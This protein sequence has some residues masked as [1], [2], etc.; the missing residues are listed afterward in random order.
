MTYCMSENR[1]LLCWY[2]SSR[3]TQLTTR[4]GWPPINLSTK[5]TFNQQSGKR[6]LQMGIEEWELVKRKPVNANIVSAQGSALQVKWYH[7]I[8]KRKIYFFSL[9]SLFFFFALVICCIC[10]VLLSS[11][12]NCRIVIVQT[13]TLLIILARNKQGLTKR[14][15]LQKNS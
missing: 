1:F 8:C 6:T 9:F 7:A 12:H 11:V 5:L 13:E 14:P 10:S 3:G 2:D 4:S 15:V